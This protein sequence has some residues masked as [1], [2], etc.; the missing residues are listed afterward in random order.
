MRVP[1]YRIRRLIGRGGMATVHLAV[2]E[3]DGEPV[4]L[5]IM[6]PSRTTGSEYSARFLREGRMLAEL[7]HP[8]VVRIHEVGTAGEDLYIAMEY[9]GGGTLQDRIQGGLAPEHALEMTAQVAE[10]LAAAHAR[11]IVHRDIKPANILLREDGTPVLTDFGIAKRQDDGERT[12]TGVIVGSPHY[13]SPEQAERSDLLDGRSDIYSLGI[14]CHEML[15]GSR[16]YE[17]ESAIRVVL[18]HAQAPL[19][20][21][22]DHL[23]QYQ[24]LLDRMLAKQPEERIQDAHVLA[25]CARALKDPDIPQNAAII[26]RFLGTNP[27][28]TGAALEDPTPPAGTG[29]RRRRLLAVAGVT[30]LILALSLAYLLARNRTPDTLRIVQGQPQP[31]ITAESPRSPSHSPCK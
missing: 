28:A 3:S 25:L 7:R 14:L 11:H 13:L 30:A 5:K 17:G 31:N 10:A 24:P 16:P 29:R 8:N 19:P 18:Q 22:P 23:A 21:L 15:T 27:G 4:V 9:L 1:G 2:R 12:F 6:R 20:R 26:E